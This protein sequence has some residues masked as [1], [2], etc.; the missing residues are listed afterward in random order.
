MAVDWG[1]LTDWPGDSWGLNEGPGLRDTRGLEC[2]RDNGR[3][4]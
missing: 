1:P 3:M 4:L 2:V